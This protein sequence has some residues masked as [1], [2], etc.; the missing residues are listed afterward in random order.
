MFMLTVTGGGYFGAAVTSPFLFI[1]IGATLAC[2]LTRSSSSRTA[3]S[4]RSRFYVF[5]AGL[6]FD[7]WVWCNGFF[8]PTCFLYCLGL[9]GIGTVDSLVPASMSNM[10]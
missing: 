3:S 1:A 9:M 4:S 2:A 8:D 7:R 5:E 6:C 10:F